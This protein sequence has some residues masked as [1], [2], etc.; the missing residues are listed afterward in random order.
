MRYMRLLDIQYFAIGV[1]SEREGRIAYSFIRGRTL[2]QYYQFRWTRVQ[3]RTLLFAYY[4][5]SLYT[6]I[7]LIFPSKTWR[8]DLATRICSLVS[9]LISVRSL[10]TILWFYEYFTFQCPMDWSTKSN[11]ILICTDLFINFDLMTWLT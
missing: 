9:F 3:R 4:I 10:N 1:T 2:W 6:C 11:V 8:T 5:H 7:I